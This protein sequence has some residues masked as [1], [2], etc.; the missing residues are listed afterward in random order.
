[1]TT[2]L[3]NQ[4]IIYP[5]KSLAGIRVQHWPV[6]EKGLRYDRQWMLI[7]HEHKFLSQRR[8]PQMALIKTCLQDNRLILSA[9]QMETI[10]LSL[11][12]TD[13]GQEIITQIW[14]DQCLARCVSTELD[15][16]FSDFLKQSCRLVYQPNTVTRHVDLDYGLTSDKINFSD[17]FP[18]LIVSEAALKALNEAMTFPLTMARFRPN[19]VL[20][21]CQAY[22]EDYWRKISIGG[23]NFR[24]PKPCSRC[25]IPTID[26]ITAKIN[27]EPLTTLNRLR[28]WQQK[29][30]FGQNALHDQLGNL[31]VD[32][33]V[34]I[35]VTGNPQPPLSTV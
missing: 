2:P 23:I 22:A 8:L 5:I 6:D 21:N 7:D 20:R 26:P 31:T 4:I 13:D 33:K 27:K 28:K 12:D 25:S 17:G 35:Q 16:W 11:T 29:V 9:P 32:D 15:K 19:L 14:Q 24:L 18:F 30:Y 34:L 10:H 3:L 1:M